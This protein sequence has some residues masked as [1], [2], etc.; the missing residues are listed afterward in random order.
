MHANMHEKIAKYALLKYYSEFQKLNTSDAV[1]KL[2]I[3]VKI[4]YKIITKKKYNWLA[5]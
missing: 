2:I 1:Y 5:F 4:I 3:Y